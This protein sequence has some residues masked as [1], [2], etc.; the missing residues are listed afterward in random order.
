MK[1]T[2]ACILI[3]LMF[4]ACACNQTQSDAEQLTALLKEFLDGAS[5]NDAS[6]HDRFWAEELIY[7]SSGG[8]RFG[9]ADIMNDLHSAEYDPSEP[10]IIYTAEDIRILEF[11]TTAVI[12]FRLVA[13]E[14][15]DVTE[16]LNT[17]TFVKQN[18][19][20]QAVAWQAT[21]VQNNSNR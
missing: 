17:G 15:T 12:A 10:E 7:T 9:K 20:W 1:T 14:E 4:A 2:I 6:V 3:V 16:Y 8:Q 19:L 13:A 18:G 5:R 11:G 21:K